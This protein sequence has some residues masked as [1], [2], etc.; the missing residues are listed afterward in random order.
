MGICKTDE[1]VC[2]PPA[3]DRQVRFVISYNAGMEDLVVY[4]L[5]L[6]KPMLDLK[7]Q[8]EM[9][10]GKRRRNGWI[11]VLGLLIVLFLMATVF[12]IGRR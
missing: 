9:Y 2:W 1:A 6:L 12:V 8:D 4:F 5:S 11:V 3:F 7:E 10:D